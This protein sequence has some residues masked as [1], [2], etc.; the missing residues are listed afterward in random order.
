MVRRNEKSRWGETC[1]ERPDIKEHRL[2]APRPAATS[3]PQATIS[4]DERKPPL[5][6]VVC[7]AW[8]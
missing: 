1:P 3:R 7:P 6:E 4:G 5:I 2:R 8:V